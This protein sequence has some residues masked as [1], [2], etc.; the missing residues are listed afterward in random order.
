MTFDDF[1][2]L[3]EERRSIRYFADKPV[4]KEDILRLLEVGCLAPS[5]ENIQPWRFHVIENHGLRHDL[6]EKCCYGNFIAGAGSFIVVTVDYSL[7]NSGPD[8]VWNERELDYSCMAAMTNIINAAT[9]MGLGSC[10]VSLYRGDVHDILKLPH[11]EHV[12]GGIMLGHFRKGEEHG[13]DGHDRKP[14][15][16]ICTF[17]E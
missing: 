15:A 13:H 6:M 4:K 3:C 5:V 9:A 1:K 17:H 8:T 11:G 10:W 7:E 12:V 16:D 2:K 14:I